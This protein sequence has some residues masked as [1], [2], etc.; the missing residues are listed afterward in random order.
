WGFASGLHRVLKSG[1]LMF[2]GEHMRKLINLSAA[3]LLAASVFAGTTGDSYAHASDCTHVAQQGKMKKC[4]SCKGKGTITTKT[5][6]GT[7]GGDGKL[8]TVQALKLGNKNFK[9]PTCNGKG[10]IQTTN[11]CS[12]CWGSGKVPA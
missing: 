1:H 11:T 2:I 6:C 8:S 7:C 9:C 10:K 5:K 12:V 3:V 4:K